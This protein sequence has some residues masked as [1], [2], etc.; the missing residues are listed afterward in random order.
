MARPI[1]LRSLLLRDRELV[2]VIE[3]RSR[4]QQLAIAMR[5]AVSEVVGDAARSEIT[6]DLL[7]RAL[8]QGEAGMAPL[9]EAGAMV[10]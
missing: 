4:E 5:Q 8:R 2:E 1:L 9:R 7:I 6:F 3:T 10:A